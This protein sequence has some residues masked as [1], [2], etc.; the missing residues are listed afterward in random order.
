MELLTGW[1]ANEE[2]SSLLLRL[3]FRHLINLAILVI[4]RPLADLLAILKMP[5]AHFSAIL[6]EP[7][8]VADHDIA[9]HL[10]LRPYRPV[11]VILDMFCALGLL[12]G[13]RL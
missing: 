2:A 6:A 4:G 5:R 8:P 3:H 7:L 13:H 9:S 12:L 1:P 10:A 11:A